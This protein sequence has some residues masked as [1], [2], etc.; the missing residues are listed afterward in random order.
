[1]SLPWFQKRRG[2]ENTVGS[3]TA[4]GFFHISSDQRMYKTHIL[5]RLDGTSSLRHS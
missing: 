2:D 5:F 3:S 4:A 1:M